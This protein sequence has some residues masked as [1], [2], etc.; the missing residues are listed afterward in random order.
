MGET[1][2][3][4]TWLREQ[5][6]GPMSWNP[7]HADTCNRLIEAA[8]EVERLRGELKAA[9]SELDKFQNPPTTGV[10]DREVWRRAAEVETAIDPPEKAE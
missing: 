2:D 10:L 9:Y 4:V 5:A 3:S 8:D 1:T 7:E 6:T